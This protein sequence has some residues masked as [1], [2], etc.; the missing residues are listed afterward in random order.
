M[1]TT[2]RFAM[3][4]TLATRTVVVDYIHEATPR[5]QYYFKRTCSTI[6]SVTTVYNITATS[7]RDRYVCFSLFPF[8]FCHSLLT[9]LLSVFCRLELIAKIEVPLRDKQYF[10]LFR[11]IGEEVTKFL[12]KR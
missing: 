9:S 5:T 1:Q 2:I 4:W 12:I 8:S 11:E 7:I 10:T 3:H 6:G